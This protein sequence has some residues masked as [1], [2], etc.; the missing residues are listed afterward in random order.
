MPSDKAN[1]TV[2]RMP[3]WENSA[4]KFTTS[5]IRRLRDFPSYYPELRLGALGNW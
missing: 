4:L 1:L 2:I 3:T 5:V